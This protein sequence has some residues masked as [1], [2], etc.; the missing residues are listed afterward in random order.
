MDEM[1]DKLGKFK[2]Y[3]KLDLNAVFY[4]ICVNSNDREVTVFKT[5]HGWHWLLVR[6][7][8]L[9]EALATLYLLMN[10]I[11]SKLFDRFLVVYLNDLPIYTDRNEEHLKRL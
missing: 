9:C 11:F 7:M 10:S 3:R 4:K 8:G 2:V 5:I 1:F 6:P